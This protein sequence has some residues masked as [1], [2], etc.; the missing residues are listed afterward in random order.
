MRRLNYSLHLIYTAVLLNLETL[1]LS[2]LQA[3]YG[4]NESQSTGYLQPL[5][6]FFYDVTFHKT[7][8]H[9]S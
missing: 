1:S 7:L 9:G 8:S 5:V 4:S 2:T 6:L 3:R